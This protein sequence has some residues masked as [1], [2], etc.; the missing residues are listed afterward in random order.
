MSKAILPFARSIV[1]LLRASVSAVHVRVNKNPM[2]LRRPVTVLESDELMFTDDG[3]LLLKEIGVPL[4]KDL[5]STV[6][7]FLVIK[8]WLLAASAFESY[9]RSNQ[10]NPQETIH[11]GTELSDD[12]EVNRSNHF[13]PQDNSKSSDDDEMNPKQPMEPALILAAPSVQQHDVMSDEMV[14]SED[15][16]EHDEDIMDEDNVDEV[17]ADLVGDENMEDAVF[18]RFDFIEVDEAEQNSDSDDNDIDEAHQSD[19]D[20][21]DEVSQYNGSNGSDEDAS[22]GVAVPLASDAVLLSS[23]YAGVSRASII[24]HQPGFLGSGFIGVGHRGRHFDYHIAAPLMRDLS[25]LGRIHNS[26][27]TFT[28]K[29]THQIYS[30]S[31]VLNDLFIENYLYRFS[32]IKSYMHTSFLYRV[33]WAC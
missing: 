1:L 6:E 10:F 18:D 20:D 30:S 12:N 33:V 23:N 15:G 9:H 14:D 4:L 11:D 17:L 7:W 27:K 32:P 21:Q 25:H 13:N 31:V 29:K 24:P 19:S 26:G 2:N 22:H 28:S 8:K 16:S 5:V 3:F